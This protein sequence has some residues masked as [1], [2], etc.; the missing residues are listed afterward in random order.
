MYNFRENQLAKDL[1][2]SQYP[3]TIRSNIS[4]KRN[5]M[6]SDNFT[7]TG[8]D[9]GILISWLSG[10]FEKIGTF[11]HESGAVHVFG[12]EEYF[13]RIGSNLLTVVVLDIKEKTGSARLTVTSGGGKTGF[14]PPIGWGAE[15]SANEDFIENLTKICKKYSLDLAR[16]Q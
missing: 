2:V 9:I 16:E 12:N 15:Q 4:F 14:L 5:R 13:F 7:I 3:N 10:T 11:P 8:N 1:P 6:E